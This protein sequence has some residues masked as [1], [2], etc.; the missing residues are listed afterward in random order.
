MV[1]EGFMNATNGVATVRL[2]HTMGVSEV[3]EPDWERNAI[4]SIRSSTGFNH[5]LV[6]QDSGWY[7]VKDLSIDENTRYILHIKTQ[8]GIEYVSDSIRV[9]KTPPIDKLNFGISSDGESLNILVTTHDPLNKTRYYKWDFVETYEYKASFYSGFHF[10]DN[11]LIY[12]KQEEQV[13]TCWLS[14]PSSTISIGTSANLAEDTIGRHLVTY[15]PKTSPKISVRYSILV[16]QMAISEKEFH[17]LEQLKNTTEGLGGMFGT[18]PT[19]V[20]GNIHRVDDAHAPVL[21][22]FS[23][24]EIKEKRLFVERLDLPKSLRVSQPKTGCELKQ[25]CEL[26][27][28]PPQFGDPPSCVPREIVPATSI[29]VSAERDGYPPFFTFTTPDCGDCRSKGGTTRKPPFW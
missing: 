6:P 19:S 9:K 24:A 1:V 7:A 25:T 17:Y 11:L 15:V 20:T 3:R 13:Y 26:S 22:Y 10:R 2:T 23:G 29:V 8:S 14:L 21:G 5:V 28:T 4:V 12:R 27:P 16:K 18:I